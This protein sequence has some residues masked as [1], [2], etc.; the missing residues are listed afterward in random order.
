MVGI[1]VPL[2]SSTSRLLECSMNYYVI[3]EL[4]NSTIAYGPYRSEQSRDNRYDKIEGGELH[5]F[6]TFKADN[7]QAIQEFRDGRVRNL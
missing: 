6:D 1:L 4:G 5:K 3:Q 7:D 2:A